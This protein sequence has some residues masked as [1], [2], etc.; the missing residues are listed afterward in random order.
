MRRLNKILR[1]FGVLLVPLPYPLPRGYGGGNTLR[2]H[3]NVSEARH[4]SRGGRTVE[5]MRRVA[6]YLD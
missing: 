5:W 1:R 4:P 2:E 3:A 6:G